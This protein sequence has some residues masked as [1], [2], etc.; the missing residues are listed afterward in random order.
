MLSNNKKKELESVVLG[1]FCPNCCSHEVKYYEYS[2]NRVFGF[3][4][5]NCGWKAIYTSSE[6]DAISASWD[7]SQKERGVFKDERPWWAE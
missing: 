5:K 3:D 4:C 1:G 2:E 6:F 7:A